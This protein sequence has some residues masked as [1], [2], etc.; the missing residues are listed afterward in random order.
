MKKNL[1]FKTIIFSMVLMFT[2]P[3]N[4]YASVPDIIV[5]PVAGR[6]YSEAKISVAYDGT[7][8]Y[9]RLY[10]E[11]SESG[12]MKGYEV[13]KSSDNGLTFTPF[14]T[15]IVLG[16]LNFTNIDIL[17]AGNDAGAVAEVDRPA[18]VPVEEPVLGTEGDDRSVLVEH[19]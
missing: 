8:Y 15:L 18:L 5:N 9:G 17:A 19:N 2:I 10:S 11:V 4:S 7:I 6:Y 13:L 1:L 14:N 16:S 12:P 3:G